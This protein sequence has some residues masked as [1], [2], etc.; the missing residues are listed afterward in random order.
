MCTVFNNIWVWKILILFWS[1][2]MHEAAVQTPVNVVKFFLIVTSWGFWIK[3]IPI[4][5]FF[6]TISLVYNTI[7][8]TMHNDSLSYSQE[9]IS[10]NKI[11]FIK[12]KIWNYQT[13]Y[14]YI[15]KYKY[16]NHKIITSL[17]LTPVNFLQ[18]L[19][20]YKSVM[21]M[22]VLNAHKPETNR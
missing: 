6:I 14:H 7:Q 3:Q 10:K 18:S 22:N 17:N 9:K 12:H 16:E 15:P 1:L 8:Y 4:Y 5:K 11:N 21:I 19:Y 20:Y 2:K 13:Q